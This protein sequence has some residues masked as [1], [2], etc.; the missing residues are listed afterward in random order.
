M[1]DKIKLLHIEDNDDFATV[2]EMFVNL[3]NK[4]DITRTKT[5]TESIQKDPN[6]FDIIICDLWLEQRDWMATIKEVT[7]K[8]NTT[9]IIIVSALDSPEY[10]RQARKYGIL[11]MYNKTQMTDKFISVLQS[12]KE[13]TY[14]PKDTTY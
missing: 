13:N 14:E 5:L 11:D 2:F 9:P 4:F 1:T 7:K 6:E 12:I 8:F 10:T 3:G